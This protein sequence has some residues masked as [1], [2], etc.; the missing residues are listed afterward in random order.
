MLAFPPLTAYILSKLR[1]AIMKKFIIIT[2]LTLSSLMVMDSFNAGHALV[3]FLLVGIV[4]G[5]DIVVSATTM[6]QI[7]AL[8]AGLTLSRLVSKP[9]RQLVSRSLEPKASVQATRA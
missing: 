5:T 1:Y 9:F 8:F 4:P 2:C 6:L 7:V 3:M